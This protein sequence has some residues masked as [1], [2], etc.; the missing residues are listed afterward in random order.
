M[1]LSMWDVQLTRPF[2]SIEL[3]K[4]S[5][6][7]EWSPD[8]SSRLAVTCF[9]DQLRVV[10]LALLAEAAGTSYRSKTSL[11]KA[12]DATHE[13][14]PKPIIKHST[15]TGRWVVP[16]RATWTAAGDALLVGD[17]KRSAHVYDATSGRRVARLHAPELMTAI[18]SRNAAHPN[19]RAIAA[20]TNSGRIH[21]FEA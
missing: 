20:A 13:L 9:D 14:V 2:V 12:H 6:A 16:F 11:S 19:G 10:S 8:G 3:P 15:Q 1:R 18:P 4:A 7:A 21:L 17:M 5:Q